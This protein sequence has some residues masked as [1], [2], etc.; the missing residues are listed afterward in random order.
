MIV[1]TIVMALPTFLLSLGTTP[2]LFLTYVM[3]GS[4]GE[5][6]WQPRFLQHVTQIAP[7]DKMGA[8]VGIANLPWFLTKLIVGLYVGFF[9]QG[10]IPD[11]DKYPNIVQNPQEMWLFFAF[12]AMI[13][14]VALFLARNWCDVKN[15]DEAKKEA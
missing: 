10:Y 7:K 14:P 1:G 3:I 4:I 13:S 2:T 15:P 11:P 12:I 6:I 8:Y 5:S 9:I